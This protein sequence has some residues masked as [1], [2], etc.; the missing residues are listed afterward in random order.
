MIEEI[1]RE[2]RVVVALIDLVGPARSCTVVRRRGRGCPF[3]KRSPWR[4]AG[5]ESR[6]STVVELT[7]VRMKAPLQPW[8]PSPNYLNPGA[9][10]AAR[11]G[12]PNVAVRD[13]LHD[14]SACELGSVGG[15]NGRDVLLVLPGG[16]Y[17]EGATDIVRGNG[18]S[19]N[20]DARFV[21]YLSFGFP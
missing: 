2:V 9:E 15:A 6:L 7:A 10:S 13:A 16:H 12:V 20:L 11:I 3:V 8:P 14:F 4:Q 19:F 5:R 17:L 21:G 18:L 1:L